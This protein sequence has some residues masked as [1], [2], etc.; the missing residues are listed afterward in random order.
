MLSTRSPPPC[1]SHCRRCC[2]HS[3]FLISLSAAFTILRAWCNALIR[4]IVVTSPQDFPM[5]IAL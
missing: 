1:A 3:Q 5:V 4:A 2:C